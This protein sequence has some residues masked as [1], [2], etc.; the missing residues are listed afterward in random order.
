MPDDSGGNHSLTPGYEAITG[1]TIQPSQHNPPLEDLSD[2]MS[3]RYM[4][5]GRTPL[6]GH[7]PMN[8]YRATNAADAVDDQDYVTLGQAQGL[9]SD[10]P[11]VHYT[12][13][14][15]A[16]EQKAQARANIGADDPWRYQPIGVP[17]PL[18]T[19]LAGVTAPPRNQEYR[20][21]KLTAG[22]AY[23]AGVLTDESV[24]GSAPL[25]VATAII[26]FDG[27]PLD[28]ATVNL[29]NTERRFLRAGSAG[30]AQNDQMQQITGK[31]SAPRL[32]LYP[33]SG[34]EG[35][36]TAEQGEQQ[37]PNSGGTNITLTGFAFDSAD[38]PDAR[39]GNE[40]RP[41]NIGVDYFMRIA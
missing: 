7:I 36:F 37:F 2:A 33:D 17:I 12:P 38:S 10:E 14:S 34:V 6:L 9:I 11:A 28:G 30:T 1:Q 41:K 31:I 35:A 18:F 39:T 13:Q 24:S 16:V 40:T 5:D 27:S 26:D 4:R 3:R 29:I 19:N 25:V 23:N 8:G 20:Y 32:G 21:I 15:L 22:D